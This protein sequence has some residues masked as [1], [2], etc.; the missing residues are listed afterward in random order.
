VYDGTL[1]SFK[2]GKLLVS[3]P[4]Q[5]VNGVAFFIGALPQSACSYPALELN[6]TSQHDSAEHNLGFGKC[7]PGQLVPISASQG[8]WQ[9]PPGHFPTG[10]GGG[11][12][13]RTGPDFSPCRHDTNYS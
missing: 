1:G 4:D 7:T 12:S 2:P 8:I 11:P 9:T 10:F 5:V 3:P 6:T 13:S